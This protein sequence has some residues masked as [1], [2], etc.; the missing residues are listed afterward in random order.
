MLR[1]EEKSKAVTKLVASR[2]ASALTHCVDV[3]QPSQPEAAVCRGEGQVQL[4]AATPHSD[5]ADPCHNFRGEKQ[6]LAFSRATSLRKSILT[7][8]AT[9]AVKPP[10][11]N[12]LPERLPDPKG[13]GVGR[14]FE[15]EAFLYFDEHDRV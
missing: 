7:Q 13:S 5:G 3:G 12:A 9:P 15:D 14:W 2:R 11:V 6:K 1:N 4:G 10:E 8:A